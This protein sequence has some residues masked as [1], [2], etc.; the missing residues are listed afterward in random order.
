[1]PGSIPVI[2]RMF[3][4]QWEEAQAAWVLLYP[5]GMVQLNASAAE[6]LT[7]IDGIK[8][9]DDIQAELNAKYPDAEDLEQDVNEFFTH[10]Q[11]L[12]WID[13]V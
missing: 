3:R 8:S 2:N 10:A 9:V 7:R 11:T 5:E 6:I 13:Y 1:M 4:L 12:N